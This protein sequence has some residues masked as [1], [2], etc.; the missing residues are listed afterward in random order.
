MNKIMK[1]VG[2]PIGI[3]AFISAIVLGFL[4]TSGTILETM[5][6]FSWITVGFIAAG[7]L[8]GIFAVQERERAMW[9]LTFLGLSAVTW[10]IQAVAVPSGIPVPA[11]EFWDKITIFVGKTMYRIFQLVSSAT[12]VVVFANIYS[13]MTKN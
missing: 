4:E 7:F 8:I 5:K 13:M 6:Y 2:T 10:G 9:I 11:A 1:R 3:I 12:V